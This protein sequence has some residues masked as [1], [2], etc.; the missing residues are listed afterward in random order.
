MQSG[1]SNISQYNRTLQYTELYQTLILPELALNLPVIL[2]GD[3]NTNYHHTVNYC[4]MLET[5]TLE[6]YPKTFANSLCSW[7]GDFVGYLYDHI[8][9]SHHLNTTNQLVESFSYK[10]NNRFK[11]LSDHKHLNITIER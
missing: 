9:T 3:L 10:V 8:L 11:P 1:E 4:N 2:G 7:G 5:L 6:D